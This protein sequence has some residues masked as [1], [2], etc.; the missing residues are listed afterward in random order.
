MVSIY[1]AEPRFGRALVIGISQS[2]ASPDI[3]GVLAAARRQG[4]PTLAITNEPDSAL[5]DAAEQVLA[6]EA[7]PELA[8]AATKTYTAEVLALALLAA[9][10]QRPADPLAADPDLA[11]VPAAVAEALETEADVAGV[12]A[13]LARTRRLRR[14]RAR[15]RVRDRARVGAQAEGARPRPRR[16][17][18][19]GRLP[20][21]A[22]RPRRRRPARARDRAVRPVRPRHG[23]APRPPAQRAR[24][25]RS[26]SPPTVPTCA[27]RDGGRSRCRPCPSTLSRSPR[28]CPASSTRCTRRSSAGWTRSGR[29]ASPR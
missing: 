24:G 3:V 4:A 22:D 28:S 8:V 19:G 25:A 27:P 20:S 9:G 2:G 6:L 26:S 11:R 7:G 5:A 17:V 18:L 21:W 13:E 29:A 1:G 16:P 10:L 23:G 14:R 12:A 15:L